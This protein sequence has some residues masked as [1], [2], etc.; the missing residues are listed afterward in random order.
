VLDLHRL[1]L[2]RPPVE[3]LLPLDE[4]LG[5][6][7]RRLL[8]ELGAGPGGRF[9]SVYQPMWQVLGEAA[10]PP[11]ASDGADDEADR[12]FVGEPRSLPT[13]WDD[14]WQAALAAWMGVENLEARAAAPGWIDPRVLAFLREKASRP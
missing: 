7:I 6:E 13:G 14:G 9:A 12:P 3:S 2:D 10:P 11:P 4:T 8:E 1:Y 5:G